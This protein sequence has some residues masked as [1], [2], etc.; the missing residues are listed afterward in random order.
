V[1]LLICPILFFRRQ[2]FLQEVFVQFDFLVEITAGKANI[3]WLTDMGFHILLLNTF[4]IT[5]LDA[6]HTCRLNTKP[7]FFGWLT[8]ISGV[9]ISKFCNRIGSEIFS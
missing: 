1:N 4:Q 9:R 5:L 7:G 2:Y 8:R 3:N 6:T